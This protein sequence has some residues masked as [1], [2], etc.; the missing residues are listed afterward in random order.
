MLGKLSFLHQ[1]IN[2][3]LFMKCMNIA[4]MHCMKN[5]MLLTVLVDEHAKWNAAGVEAVQEILHIAADKRIKTKLCFVFDDTLSHSG[6]NIIV[7]VS[8]L[9]QDLKEAENIKN[10]GCVQLRKWFYF[11]LIW[12]QNMNHQKVFS[13]F[14]L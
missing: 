5:V 10:T 8:N 2:L 6:D 3:Q 1:V 14:T 4:Y 7:P 13:S 12:S 11:I 9:N